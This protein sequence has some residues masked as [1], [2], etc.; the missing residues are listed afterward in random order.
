VTAAEEDTDGLY[1]SLQD[2]WSVGPDVDDDDWRDYRDALDLSP[3][4]IFDDVD[5]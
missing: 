3:A 2:S 5:E 4:S 1:Q